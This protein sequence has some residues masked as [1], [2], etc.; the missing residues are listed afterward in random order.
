MR[1]LITLDIVAGLILSAASFYIQFRIDLWE[2]SFMAILLCMVLVL[3]NFILIFTMW[4]EF[5][6]SSLIPFAISL[7]L[8]P[9]LVLSGFIGH[10]IGMYDI[11]S[12]PEKYFNEERKKELTNIAEELLRAQDEK[13]KQAIEEKLYKH[14]RLVV[15]NIDRYSNIVEFSYYRSRIYSAYIYAKDG[16][17]EI[18]ST[19]PIITEEDISSWAELINMAKV[20]NSSDY[21]RGEIVFVP[22]IAYPFLIAKLDKAFITKL[23]SMESYQDYAK[24][25]ETNPVLDGA[26]RKWG[27]YVGFIANKISEEEKKKVMEILN[28]QC[29]ISSGLVDNNNINW[30]SNSVTLWLSKTCFCGFEVDRHLRHLI[31]EGVITIRDKEGHLQVKPNLN[32]RKIREIEWLQVELMRHIYGNLVRKTEYWSNEKTKLADN[33]YFYQD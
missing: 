9:S 8:A 31:S 4:R 5:R 15:H 7:F 1:K 24:K 12:C 28:Q 17:P 23:I 16:L 13:N 19:K 2:L 6:Y 10:K 18:Y 20:G 3:I 11:P 25:Y 22:E 32:D 30:R 21:H 14:H 29:E 33:W 26:G 27:R